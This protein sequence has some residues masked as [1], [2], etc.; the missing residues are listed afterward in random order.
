MLT[1]SRR[2]PAQLACRHRTASNSTILRTKLRRANRANVQTPCGAGT[3]RNV[4]IVAIKI[5]EFIAIAWKMYF[6]RLGCTLRAVDA[7]DTLYRPHGGDPLQAQHAAQSAIDEVYCTGRRCDT[8]CTKKRKRQPRPPVIA[9]FQP[10][11]Q[12]LASPSPEQTRS[13]AHEQSIAPAATAGTVRLAGD[14]SLQCSR[15]TRCGASRQ[16]AGASGGGGAQG[17][18]PARYWKRLGVPWPTPRNN[19]PAAGLAYLCVVVVCSSYLTEP[20]WCAWCAA[21]RVHVA[22]VP[23]RAWRRPTWSGSST[24]TGGV[25]APCAL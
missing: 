3:P 5:F 9:P 8:A 16:I 14:R 17:W 19:E 2:C 10:K 20:W 21:G 12:R 25:P 1:S 4:G 22:V 7:F 6:G 11:Q 24:R 18:T 13:S 15:H 23:R